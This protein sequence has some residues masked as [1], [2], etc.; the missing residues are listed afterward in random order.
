MLFYSLVVV[1][2]LVSFQTAFSFSRSQISMNTSPFASFLDV[3]K[4]GAK[5][6]SSKGP[7][8]STVAITGASGL[9]GRALTKSL[10]QQQ[11]KV[12]QITTKRSKN[13]D[14]TVIW[15]PLTSSIDGVEKLEGLD[16]VVHLAGENVASGEGILSFL[17]LWTPSKKQKILNSRVE[18]TRLLIETLSQLKKKPKTLISASGIGYYGFKDF[19]TVFDE[20]KVVQGE[21]NVID[22]FLCFVVLC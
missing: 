11:I 3:L 4:P 15:D 12:V 19:D 6:S 21:G 22:C 17:G 8:I 5:S 1:C 10:R 13:G 16:A 20:K 9:V 14:N 7:R 2:V 18:G